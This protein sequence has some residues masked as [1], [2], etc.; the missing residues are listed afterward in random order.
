MEDELETLLKVD[1]ISD[2]AIE[3]LKGRQNYTFYIFF[4]Y[5]ERFLNL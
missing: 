3:K 5:I 1:G 2:D 4:K